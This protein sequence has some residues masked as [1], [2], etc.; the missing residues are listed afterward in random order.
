MS[1]YLSPEDAFVVVASDGVWE[2][3]SNEEVV[4]IIAASVAEGEREH[5][6]ERLIAE[7]STRWDREVGGKDDITALVAFLD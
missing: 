6:C 7:A 1:V 3:M 5:C 4:G 2:F